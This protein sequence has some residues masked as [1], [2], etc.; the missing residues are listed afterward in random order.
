MTDERQDIAA[1]IQDA[2]HQ[3]KPLNITAGNT[4]S[5]YGRTIDAEPLSVIQHTGITEYEP[6]EL[7]I[8]ARGGT[9]LNEIEQTIQD[10]NQILPFEPPHFG[11]TTTLGGCIASGLS[12]PRRASS[13]AV[14][15]CI[16]GTEIINGK[17]EYLCFG[18]KVMKNVA[19]Y[20][21]SRMMSGSLGTLGILMSITIRL[22]PKPQKEQTLIFSMPANDAILQMNKWANTPLP[23]SASFYD[24]ANLYIRLSGSATTLNRC[25]KDLGGELIDEHE[26]FWLNIKEQVHEFFLTE[27]PLWRISVPS[28][29]PN[30]N[31]SGDTVME[32][33][34]A[35]RWYATEQNE[36][37][38]REETQRAGGH[39][40]LF[41]GEHTQQKF[42][43]LSDTAMKIHKNLNQVF[44][45]AGILNPGKMYAEL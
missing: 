7:Y 13:G 14:R 34:G 32:W 43:P 39:A 42:H 23:I 3:N 8:S 6:S 18:G 45:S 21:V 22:L 30:L 20:D 38:I 26:M 28:S 36:S 44:D 15:D 33:N 4:K 10:E 17:G 40:T 25:E 2:Y 31:I 35:L 41:R 9:S 27:L 11:T 16:L 37:H 12:G 24:G 1:R 5:F 19:G 29:S